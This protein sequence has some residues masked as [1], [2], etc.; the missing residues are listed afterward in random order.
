VVGVTLSE[1]YTVD[2]D[3]RMAPG[4]TVQLADYTYQFEGV[5]DVRGP[6][7]QAREGVVR[8]LRGEEEVAI[9]Y[10]QKRYYVSQEN[11]MTEAAID[12]AFT[13]DLYVALGEPA[14][15]DGAWSVRVYYKPF[16]MWLWLGPTLMGIGGLVAA[17][18][19]RY[20]QT[21]RAERRAAV[22][23]PAGAPAPSAP[24]EGHA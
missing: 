6:N 23:G 3:V 9:L 7:Y 14:G 13:R 24:A 8:V 20:R 15:A 17:S 22:E 11:P 19:R 12:G 4:D 18:D 2:R 1:A 16:V 21:A 5:R 10:P